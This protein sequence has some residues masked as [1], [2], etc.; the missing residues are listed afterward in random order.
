MQSGYERQVRHKRGKRGKEKKIETRHTQ[1][2]VKRKPQYVPTVGLFSITNQATALTTCS[3]AHSTAP[4]PP[5]LGCTSHSDFL[6]AT[7]QLP[8]SPQ[9][10]AAPQ[11]HLLPFRAPWKSSA[12]LQPLPQ[13]VSPPP[14]VLGPP[15]TPSAHSASL[16]VGN[17]LAYL[18]HNKLC[19]LRV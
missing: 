16:S 13:P 1:M 14:A 17:K 4:S 11:T 2:T 5:R 10:F 9:F 6:P 18:F 7:A 8:C 12:Q 3:S 19:P 15:T